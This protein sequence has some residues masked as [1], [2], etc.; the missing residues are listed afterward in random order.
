VTTRAKVLGF[1]VELDQRGRVAAE[2]GAAHELPTEL[3]PEHLVL[4]GLA[5]CTLSSLAYHAR[6]ADFG[7]AH[8]SAQAA[9]RVTRREP[10]G[11]YAFVEIDCRL[12]ITL[13]PSPDGESIQTL[14]EEAERDCFVG[15]SLTSPPRYSWR[16]NGSD[17]T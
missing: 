6:R 11:R 15:A 2:D 7:V 9:G 5:R 14:V 13:H 17:L 4:A 3:K 1:A 8:A 12:D 10:D 16:V